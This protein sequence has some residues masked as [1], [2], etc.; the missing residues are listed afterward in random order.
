M[1]FDVQPTKIDFP[2][3]DLCCN[4]VAVDT[5]GYAI[6]TLVRKFFKQL[7]LGKKC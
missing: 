5:D 1:Y 6:D 7:L 4:R 3:G 2:S